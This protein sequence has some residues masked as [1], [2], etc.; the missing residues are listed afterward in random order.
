MGPVWMG[1]VC[2]RGAARL[3]EHWWGEDGQAGGQNTPPSVY[4]EEGARARCCQQPICTVSAN[5]VC[6]P[7]AHFP[8]RGCWG[9]VFPG[10]GQC[11]MIQL[12]HALW[13]I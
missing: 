13:L 10:G 5:Q 8:Q 12:G 9:I 6:E 11:L 4:S 1:E 7:S 2:V 3:C